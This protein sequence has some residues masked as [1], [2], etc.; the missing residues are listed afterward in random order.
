MNPSESQTP[1]E[2]PLE[3]ALKPECDAIRADLEAIEKRIRALL[4]RDGTQ[5]SYEWLTRLPAFH[6]WLKDRSGTISGDAL[7]EVRDHQ[8]LAV[9][10]I[11]DA[12]MRLGKV[13]QHSRDGVSVYDQPKPVVP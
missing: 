2:Y 11:E 8:M 10:A 5:T 4:P 12:R 13:L 7:A 3:D 1:R 6:S 9:R